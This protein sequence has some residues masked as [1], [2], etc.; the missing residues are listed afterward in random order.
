M[1]ISGDDRVLEIIGKAV[2][3]ITE[4]K[5][6]LRILMHEQRGKRT[7][8]AKAV[9]FK[10]LALPGKP[11]IARKWVRGGTHPE[12]VHHHQFA[13]VVPPGMNET[14]LGSPSMREEGSCLLYTSDAADE[15]DSVDLGGRRI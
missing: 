15:E 4:V 13:I 9:I 12:Q 6:S 11:C 2:A 3:L 5:P 10:Y 8:V 7:H 1:N 14:H